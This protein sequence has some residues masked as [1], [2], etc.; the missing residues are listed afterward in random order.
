MARKRLRA[1]FWWFGGKG[2]MSAKLLNLL[3]G[4]RTYVEP[5]CGAASLF[6]AKDPAEVET[7]NDLHSGIH[8]LFSVLRDHGA[9][10]LQ[11][12]E[13][14]PYSRELYV[15]CL[16]TW[17]EEP[18]PVRRAWQWWFVACSSFSGRW[19]AGYGSNVGKSSGGM[20]STCDQFTARIGTLPAITERLRK[21]QIEQVD[22]VYCL[23]RY[24][25]DDGL[26]YVDPPYVASTRRAGEYEH[27]FTDTDHERLVTAL[28]ALPGRFV[29]S[30]YAHA[31]YT[32]LLEAGWTQVDYDTGCFAAGRVRNSSLQGKGSVMAK[33]P[34]TESVWLD[35]VTAAEKAD[36]IASTQGCLAL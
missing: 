19:G 7:L 26:A 4:H 2:K 11:L 22:G 8:N 36:A 18:D 15:E 5:F 27:E 24:C 21:A 30:G 13:L 28:L 16:S 9:A 34:R 25:T 3:P 32:P 1:P 12:A 31:A 23:E 17:A 6:F 29:V 35:P 33:Q 14:T 10:F 20:V